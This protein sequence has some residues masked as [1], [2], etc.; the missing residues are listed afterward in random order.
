MSISMMGESPSNGTFRGHLKRATRPLM[1]A[2]LSLMF[3]VAGCSADTDPEDDDGTDD[4]FS[5]HVE[6]SEDGLASA[7]H[8]ARRNCVDYCASPRRGRKHSCGIMYCRP[9]IA[10]I[11]FY[12]WGGC[13][14]RRYW[15]NCP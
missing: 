8:R 11:G 14:C 2:A 10:S 6:K 7:C 9:I 3:V 5:E 1:A 13:V 15:R 12:S 4:D